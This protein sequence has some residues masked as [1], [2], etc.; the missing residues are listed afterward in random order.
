[1]SIRSV[2]SV[3]T[4]NHVV[5]EKDELQGWAR[6]GADGEI[7]LEASESAPRKIEPGWMPTKALAPEELLK[8]K[9]PAS[10][11][12]E[13]VSWSKQLGQLEF[14]SSFSGEIATVLATPETLAYYGVKFANRE[15]GWTKVHMEHKQTDFIYS[16]NYLDNYVL[17]D[18]EKGCC[19]KEKVEKER[20]SRRRNPREAQLLPHGHTL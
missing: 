9:R 7:V 14:P 8:S 10:T 15:E 13:D 1:M 20:W 19:K 3:F 18:K 12:V 6:R 16:A 2:V 17:V 11:V 5:S 4:H